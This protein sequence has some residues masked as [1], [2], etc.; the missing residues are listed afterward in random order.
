MPKV[1]SDYLIMIFLLLVV[2]SSGA[3]LIADFSEGV[4]TFHLLQEF[5]VMAAAAG[6]FFWVTLRVQ[7]SRAELERLHAE[8]EA[9]RKMRMPESDQ[10]QVAR[11]QLSDAI[12]EQFETWGL[13][14][15][16]REVGLLLLKGFSLKEISVLREV[17][18]KTIRQQA[19]SIYKKAD[20][21][22]RHALSAWFMED[23]L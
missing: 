20:L 18:E 1:T 14:K 7:R 15:S 4:A 3:D 12:A 16:E 9:V 5:V 21:P 19:S 10:V 6:V 11:R 8:L 17:T 13:S 2:I 22:G 23:I